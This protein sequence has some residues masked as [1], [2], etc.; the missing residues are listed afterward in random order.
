MISSDSLDEATR[1]LAKAAWEFL[2]GNRLRVLNVAPW[3]FFPDEVETWAEAFGWE[4]SHEERRQEELDRLG[5][6]IRQHFGEG[7]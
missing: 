7:P 3:S 5:E 4:K 6:V 1:D 2:Q